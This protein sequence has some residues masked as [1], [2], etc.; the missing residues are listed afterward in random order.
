MDAIGS[1]TLE[2]QRSLDRLIP[3]LENR[4][5]THIRKNPE[6]WMLFM[7]RLQTHF[8]RLF[9][10]LLRLYQDRYD[11][12]YYL[13]ELLAALAQS[14]IDRP[15]NLKTWTRSGK[16]NR[17]GTTT[18]HMLGGVCYVDL[19]AENLDGIRERIPYFKELGLTYLHLMPLFKMPEGENDGGY[20]ISS[21]RE[22][23]PP[24]GTMDDLERSGRRTA[25]RKVSAWC[26]ISSS[27]TPPTSTNGHKTP[28][29][30]DPD[31]GI[32]TCIFPDRHMP[33]AYERHLREIFPDEHP[34]AFTYH[35][36]IDA[37]GVDHFPFLPVGPELSQPG[38]FHQHGRRNA[39]PG[40]CR[41]RSPAPGCGGFHLETIGHH[42]REPA[43]SPYCSS[44]PITPSPGLPPQP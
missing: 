32:T 44:R 38:G 5:E 19:F 39:L 12:F 35:P 30:G 9:I 3:R 33:D 11:F 31:T 13:E 4:F 34:G 40:Q 42:L 28:S 37:L 2:I 27:T 22:V 41:G 14:W 8:G 15:E 1:D 20:A 43:R 16:L 17:P 6:D 26:W 36:E 7:G 18:N 21:Y 23:N 10:L 29:P 25:A 24:L